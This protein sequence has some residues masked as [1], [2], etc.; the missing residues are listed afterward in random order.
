MIY[1]AASAIT[2]LALIANTPASAQIKLPAASSAQT[3]TQDL[4]IHKVVLTYARPNVKGRTIFGGLIPYGE[5]WRTGANNATTL[6]FEGDVRIGDQ[7]IPA[8]TYGLFT[9]PGKEEWT[10]ILNKN[11]KQWGS[12]T[13]DQKDDILR[14]KVKPE[15]L[16][17]KQE[18]MTI[19]FSEV[20]TASARVTLSW[21]HTAVS[22]DILADQ[23]AEIVAAIDKAMSGTGNKPYLQAAQYYYNNNKDIDQALAWAN[24]AEKGSPTAAH[25]RYWKALIQLKKGDKKGALAT[26][27][28]GLKIATSGNNQEYIR[29]NQQVI[30]LAK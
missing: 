28:E 26:A 16:A 27:Q 23:D 13:Y 25:V 19:S 29:L 3:V 1:G 5:I 7:N 10:V 22:F 6:A 30:D 15:R 4:G 20:T 18:T 9:I 12:Y 8:G 14:L 21:E 17:N 24:E 11:S 2:A